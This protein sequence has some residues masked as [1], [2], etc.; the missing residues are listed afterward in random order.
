MVRFISIVAILAA[1]AYALPTPEA[2]P[3][4]VDLEKRCIGPHVNQATLTLVENSEGYRASAC[5][6]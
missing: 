6:F 1:T 5:K 4:E 3:V 2:V